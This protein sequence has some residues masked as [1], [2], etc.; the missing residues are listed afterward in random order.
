LFDRRQPLFQ[1]DTYLFGLL[2]VSRGQVN[3]VVVFPQTADGRTQRF[4]TSRQDVHMALHAGHR[5]LGLL[6]TAGMVGRSPEATRLRGGGDG[7]LVGRRPLVLEPYQ[8]TL[9]FPGL[10]GQRRG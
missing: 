3:G 7:G 6:D 10:G 5:L 2:S 1:L 4:L 8:A 9:C